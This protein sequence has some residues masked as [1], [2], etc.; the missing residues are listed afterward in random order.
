L[1]LLRDGCGFE[2]DFV[3]DKQTAVNA[4]CP[5]INYSSETI[6][7]AV[8]IY[9][10]LLLMETGI[11]DYT[12]EVSN[13][14]VFKKVFF[15]G[16]STD[17]PFDLFSASFWLLS[18]Y[19]EYLP[20][21]T[22]KYSRFHYKSS[23]A[24][25][26]DFLEIPL[27]NIWLN[28]FKKTLC[29]KFPLLII[30]E[31]V[32]NFVSTID[33]DNAYRYRHKGLVRTLAGVMN[34]LLK[35]DFYKIRERIEII[36]GKR[37]DPFDV[38]EFLIDAHKAKNITALCFFLLGDYGVNDKNHSANNYPFQE[39]IK[40]IADYSQIG[41]HPSFGSNDSLQKLKVEVSRL[42]NITH[43]P[44]TKSRQH[45][46][47]LTFPETYKNLLLA[48]ISDDYSMGYTNRN[49]FRASF[50]YPFNWYNL[51]EEQEVSL[52]LHPFCLTE[53]TLDYYSRTSEQA[54]AKLSAPI[55]KA[56]KDCGGELISVFHNDSFT[57]EMK[58]NYLHFLDTAQI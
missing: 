34:D 22:D 47:M 53:N 24:Y 17:L 10:H 29:A 16:V 8:H 32:Y 3:A 41:I 14:P 20:H 48:G 2:L 15:K 25:Q 42:R 5:V 18:R 40:H 46:S 38:Y 58:K 36:T 39:L 30:K 44:I 23:L 55:V 7:N 6:E 57:D 52:K 45:Y 35:K 19:E 26:Y 43:F 56:V 37:D 49:G 1:I 9:P 13:D 28:E 54:F 4:T 31:R 33:I 50:C 21:K 27:I 12:I 11:R 51:D